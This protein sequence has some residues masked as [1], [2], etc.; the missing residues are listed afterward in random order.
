MVKIQQ[1][2]A[3]ILKGIAGVKALNRSLSHST[4][5]SQQHARGSLVTLVSILSGKHDNMTIT[6]FQ[7]WVRYF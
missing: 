4:C 3:E 7:S 2:G 5:L 6:V 1:M